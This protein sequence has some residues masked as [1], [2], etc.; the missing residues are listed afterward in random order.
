VYGLQGLGSE[1]PAVRSLIQALNAAIVTP[2]PYKGY[3]DM[4]RPEDVRM[5]L[6]GLKSLNS[7]YV[8]VRNL[9]QKL[10]P[11]VAQCTKPLTGRELA[12]ALHG[13]QV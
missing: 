10:T 9:V 12:D 5:S 13:L 7:D 11:K 3:N 6:Y 2:S 4:F 1:H 8:E